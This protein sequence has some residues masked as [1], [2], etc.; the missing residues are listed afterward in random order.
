MS[1]KGVA[2]QLLLL[3]ATAIHAARPGAPRKGVTSGPGGGILT[4]GMPGG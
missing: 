1:V 3:F 2:Y 4:P